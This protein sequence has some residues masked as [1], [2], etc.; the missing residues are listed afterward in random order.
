MIFQ[1]KN[2]NEYFMILTDVMFD[3]LLKVIHFVG[4]FSLSGAE[5][6]I[7]NTSFFLQTARVKETFEREL[8]RH[9]EVKKEF[10]KIRV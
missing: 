3:C 4:N 9:S 7:F 8:K 6:I 5:R 1:H 2:Q 10:I